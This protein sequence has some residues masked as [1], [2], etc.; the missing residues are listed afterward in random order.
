[1]LHAR[2]GFAR[3]VCRGKDVLE[4]ACGPA[5][6]LNY[7]SKYARRAVGGDCNFNMLAAARSKRQLPL[8][9]LDAHCLPFADGSFDAILLYEA[10]YYLSQPQ[11]FLGE[12]RRILRPAGSLLVSLPNKRWPGFN[13]SPFSTRYFDANEL[14]E[15][16]AG[17][18]FDLEVYG[19]FPS[20]SSTRAQKARDWVRRSAVRHHLIPKSFK[21]KAWLKR[22]FYGSLRTIGEELADQEFPIDGLVPLDRTQDSSSFRVLYGHARPGTGKTSVA[23]A[24]PNLAAVL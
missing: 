18:K 20:V 12:C 7:L 1:M 21:S 17:E 14:R 15:F 22:L 2:Y 19:V 3:E 5:L 10:I 4:L 23:E 16:F 11:R 13:P 9:C 6:G 24:R 8:L